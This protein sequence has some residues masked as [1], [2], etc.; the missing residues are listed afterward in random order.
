MLILLFAGPSM[1]G[2][3]YNLF[4]NIPFYTSSKE[5]TYRLQHLTLM[6]QTFVLM[7]VFNMFNC[8]KIGTPENP[9]FNVFEYLYHN[10][11]FLIVMLGELNLQILLVSYPTVCLFFMTTP[12][13]WQMHLTA[14]LLGL[15]SLAVA[16]F[17]KKTPYAWVAGLSIAEKE[18]E[19]SLT[20]M[21]DMS[22]ERAQASA[23]L[24]D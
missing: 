12:L 6:F 16:Y 14:C 5:P 15:G 8:R 23:M 10:W 18:T 7:N 19:G 1:F 11:W 20:R 22:I 24:N 13:T 21:I 17:A 3:P 4:A 2:I 9:C